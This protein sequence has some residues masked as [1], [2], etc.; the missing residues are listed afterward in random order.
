MTQYKITVKDSTYDVEILDDPRQAEVAVK[1][2]GERFTVETEEIVWTCTCGS[3]NCREHL[4][5]FALLQL[6]L[7]LLRLFAGPVP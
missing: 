4:L 5:L 1:V 7:Q 6:P 3:Q 2:N